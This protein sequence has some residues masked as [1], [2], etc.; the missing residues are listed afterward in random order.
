MD[1]A[2]FRALVLGRHQQSGPFKRSQNAGVE[3]V[4]VPPGSIAVTLRFAI[5]L[6]V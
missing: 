1:S 6:L 5:E 2:H 3:R 4:C